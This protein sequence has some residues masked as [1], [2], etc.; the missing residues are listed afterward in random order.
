MNFLG[1]TLIFLNRV[2]AMNV[3][4]FDA[5]HLWDG[6][7]WF[8]RVSRFGRVK[9]IDQF[10]EYGRLFRKNRRRWWLESRTIQIFS[11]IPV[12][13]PFFGEDIFADLVESLCDGIRATDKSTPGSQAAAEA[14]TS[15]RILI[16]WSFVC[17]SPFE[18]GSYLWSGRGPYVHRQSLSRLPGRKTLFPFFTSLI[19]I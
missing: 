3:I 6:V 11:G 4:A 2:H 18:T 12:S 17:S 5:R 7:L 8:V 1:V 19:L 15:P 13:H 10:L 14:F 9:Q 16:S